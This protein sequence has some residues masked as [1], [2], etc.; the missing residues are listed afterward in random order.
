MRD[1]FWEGE[2][3]AQNFVKIFSNMT[4]VTSKPP[5][6]QFRQNVKYFFHCTLQI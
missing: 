4:V 2:Q 6:T 5:L 3:I 1:A